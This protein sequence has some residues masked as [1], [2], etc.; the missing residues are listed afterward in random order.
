MKIL[1][2]YGNKP[3]TINIDNKSIKFHSTVEKDRFLYLRLLQ[4]AGVISQLELQP[5]Y[6]I[7][8][9]WIRDSDKK[10]FAGEDYVADF[11]Y[12]KDGCLIVEDVKGSKGGVLL[13]SGK[14]TKDQRTELYMS[15]RKRFL[16]QN[17]DVTFVEVYRVKGNWDEIKI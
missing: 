14:K 1:A 3:V 16:R 2:K 5:K 4:L 6:Q 9:P 10:K 13:T 15:K 11:R 12:I 17:Q 7:E 8:P